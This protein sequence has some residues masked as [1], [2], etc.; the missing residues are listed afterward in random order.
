[1][2]RQFNLTKA[3][4]FTPVLTG[5]LIATVC[6]L[7][8]AIAGEA[9][10]MSETEMETEVIKS[11]KDH[12]SMSEEKMN[13]VETAV[14]AGNFQTLVAAVKAAGLVEVLSGEDKYT[15]FAPTDEAFAALGEEK[16]NELLEPENKDKLI[17]IL[18]YHVVPGVVKSSDLETDEVEVETV[19]GRSVKINKV[20]SGESVKVNE[21]MVIKA[22]IKTSNGIIHVIDTVILPPEE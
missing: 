19:E 17:S 16:L 7:P 8:P 5:M 3:V 20:N 9:V 13:L 4:K 18:T 12:T 10:E 15:V 2:I 6:S 22:D 21:A 14:G 1:M 11:D